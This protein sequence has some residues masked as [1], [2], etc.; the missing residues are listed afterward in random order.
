M[1]M[2]AALMGGGALPPLGDLI[3]FP[4]A[5]CAYLI[6]VERVPGVT[7]TPND[8]AT[9]AAGSL[10]CMPH[11]PFAFDPALLARAVED[12]TQRWAARLAAGDT[13]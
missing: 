6:D 7:I 5:V 10:V 4:C 12:A 13:P 8:A 11:I 1:S 9:L 2:L 3:K